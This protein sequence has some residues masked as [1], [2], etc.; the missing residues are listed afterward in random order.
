[1]SSQ[2]VRTRFD[3]LD[4]TVTST[5]RSLLEG[6][7]VDGVESALSRPGENRSRR[8]LVKSSREELESEAEQPR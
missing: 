6:S 1:M 8:P 2:S 5:R 4:I 7:S 3:C